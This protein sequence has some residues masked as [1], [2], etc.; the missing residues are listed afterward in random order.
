MPICF[1]SDDSKIETEAYNFQ[2]DVKV[3]T[4]FTDF[5]HVPPIRVVWAHVNLSRSEKN[6]LESLNYVKLGSNLYII[7]NSSL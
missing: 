2:T 4:F 3:G 1:F 5:Y 6:T 7:L